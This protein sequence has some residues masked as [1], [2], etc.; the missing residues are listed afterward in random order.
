MVHLALDIGGTKISGALFGPE[1]EVI[2][3]I[4]RLLKGRGGSQAAALA[5]DM[6]AELIAHSGESS[7]AEVVMGICVPG[8]AWP[9]S[10]RVWAPNI[11]GWE[12]FPL[13]EVLGSA[14]PERKTSV[15]IESDRSCHI[16]G[17]VWKGEARGC[18]DVVFMAVGTGI[19]V[20]LLCGG[21]VIRGSRN[22]AGAAGW[23]ALD[24]AWKEDFSRCG[25][26]E[27]YASGLGLTHR[28]EAF[29]LQDPDSGSLLRQ[30]PPEGLTAGLFKAYEEGDRVAREVVGQ[31]VSYWGM[32]AAN[33]VSL[34]NPEKV[35]WGGGLFGPA[36]RLL[37]DI[38]REAA[39]WA[40]P[41]AFTGVTF[42][43]SA[44][45]QDAGL[46]GAAYLA[47]RKGEV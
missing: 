11:P 26:F 25:C 42:E 35:I 10:G 31:A 13:G 22:I 6:A 32:A 23:M 24:P 44:L 12:D 2:V 46:T 38:R 30:L 1:G 7:A 28:T 41:L 40:Q 14:F 3:R 20:G 37:E 36:T 17:E 15:F 27:Y 34:L 33:L 45:D 43:A 8:I 21:K 29:F 16:L 19:G 18:N 4:K 39:R 5:V 9:G 47:L